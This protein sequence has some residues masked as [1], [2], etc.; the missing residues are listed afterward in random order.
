M[1]CGKSSSI[2]SERENIRFLFYRGADKSLAWPTSQSILFVGENI[3]FDASVFIYINSTNIPPIM[4]I[5]RIY[6]NQNLLL[7]YL[8]PFLVGH[9]CIIVSPVSVSVRPSIVIKQSICILLAFLW[10]YWTNFVISVM[11][12][13]S[14]SSTLQPWVGLGLLKQNVTSDL[15][16]G[17]PPTNFYN[18]VS[19]C[20]PL[21]RQS[22]LISVGH[23]F[24][25]H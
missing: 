21:P 25:D 5:N 7:L 3:S 23:V 9:L 22:N 1:G 19:V 20:L 17:H 4:I 15:Y 6:E 11:S 12:P 2:W 10:I 14:S 16:P 18:P 24:V 8:V 13:S